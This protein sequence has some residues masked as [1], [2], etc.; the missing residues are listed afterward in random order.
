MLGVLCLFVLHQRGRDIKPFA[1][2][3]LH[4]TADKVVSDPVRFIV[5]LKDTDQGLAQLDFYGAQALIAVEHINAPSVADQRI[6]LAWVTDISYIQTDKRVHYQGSLRQ[7]HCRAQD[8]CPADCEAR[9]G[10][11]SPS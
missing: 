3:I 11:T 4:S 7:Q 5:N 8:V 6:V 1:V 9:Y 10:H 2:V